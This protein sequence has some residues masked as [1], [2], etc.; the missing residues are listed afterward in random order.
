MEEVHTDLVAIESHFPIKCARKCIDRTVHAPKLKW[1]RARLMCIWNCVSSLARLYFGGSWTL[2]IWIDDFPPKFVCCVFDCLRLFDSFLSSSPLF[3]MSVVRT[4]HHNGIVCR[5]KW[6]CTDNHNARY[7]SQTSDT[8]HSYTLMNT[9]IVSA[10]LGI[11]RLFSHRWNGKEKQ[12]SIGQ[13]MWRRLKMYDA[14]WIYQ[15]RELKWFQ[16]GKKTHRLLHVHCSHQHL[17][18]NLLFAKFGGVHCASATT[19]PNFNAHQ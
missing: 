7:K 13:P 10:T 1:D 16:S 8:L 11:D 6:L 3:K 19:L 15:R 18:P 2:Q 12:I 5:S 17:L 9:E 4:P 14:T